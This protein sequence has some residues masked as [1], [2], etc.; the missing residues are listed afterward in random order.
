MG[1]FLCV[2]LTLDS[3][4]AAPSQSAKCP[5]GCFPPERMVREPLKGDGSGTLRSR[6]GHACG[7]IRFV[8][9][10][11]GRIG[12]GRRERAGVVST[13]LALAEIQGRGGTGGWPL[14]VARRARRSRLV[15]KG[16][17]GLWR[18]VSPVGGSSRL[19]CSHNRR[20][21]GTRR[22]GRSYSSVSWLS[23]VEAAFAADAPVC[24]GS[25]SRRANGPAC[26]ASHDGSRR[27]AMRF[28]RPV[29]RP[30]SLQ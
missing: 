1:S 2:A 20:R 19:W 25:S 12:H 3:T 16:A 22:L 17:G 13:Q 18:G 9:G 24:E 21:A 30:P 6:R 14:A 5:T 7:P 23:P 8:D 28:S 4:P 27:R 26:E 29:R 15:K 11:H 10:P